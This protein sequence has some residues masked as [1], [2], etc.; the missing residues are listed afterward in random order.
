MIVVHSSNEY[1]R[2]DA[3]R[4]LRVWPRRLMAG[5]VAGLVNAKGGVMTDEG[6]SYRGFH[7]SGPNQHGLVW[8]VK[9]Y[10]Q[11][12]AGM[13]V[14]FSQDVAAAASPEEA[15]EKAKRM[16]DTWLDE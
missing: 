9:V 12:G 1:H 2:L 13:P 7:L 10:P 14:P 8:Q 4:R 16:V 5:E 15:M 6:E 11:R 3:S